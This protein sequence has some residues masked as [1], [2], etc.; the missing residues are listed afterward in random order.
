MSSFSPNAPAYLANGVSVFPI[1][2]LA[3]SAVQP[4]KRAPGVVRFHEDRAFRVLEYIRTNRAMDPIVVDLA[5]ISGSRYQYRLCDG[6]HR[7]HLS[8][9]LGFTHIYAAI[10][11]STEP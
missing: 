10:N 1:E 2:I 5:V 3:L 4:V 8:I 7:F 11:P 6:F 9:A